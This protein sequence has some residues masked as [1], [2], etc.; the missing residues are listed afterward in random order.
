MGMLVYPARFGGGGGGP[1]DPDFS[2]VSSLVPFDGSDGSTTFT[3]IKGNT[4]VA[5]GNAKLDTTIK[6][7]G[8]AA[9][10]LDGSSNASSTGTAFQ[11]GTGDFTIECWFYWDGFN[12]NVGIFS[13]ALASS[14]SGTVGLA[15]LTGGFYVQNNDTSTLVSTSVSSG[16]WYHCAITREGTNLRFRFNGNTLATYTDS[17]NI[18]S[19]TMAVGAYYSSFY[20]LG[21]AVDDFRVSKGLA[22]Y[23]GTGTYTIPTAAFPTS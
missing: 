15:V 1:T 9:L 11:L 18:S 6:K 2:Y 21:G 4:W 17:R 14:H 20:A 13:T 5:N 7:W 16:T 12:S 22:R 10:E 8:S 19:T 23:T 3:D